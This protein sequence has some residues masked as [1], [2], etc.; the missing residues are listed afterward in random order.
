MA[1]RPEGGKPGCIYLK[2][3]AG[4]WEL[5]RLSRAGV[6]WAKKT[7]DR[8]KE[9]AR[10][11]GFSDLLERYLRPAEKAETLDPRGWSPRIPRV[12]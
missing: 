12:G 10:E 4:L 8:L 6:D 7:V 9:I 5:V 2:L 1:K 11:R 3:P